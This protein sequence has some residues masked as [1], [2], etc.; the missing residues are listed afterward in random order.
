[1]R[2]KTILFKIKTLVAYTAFSTFA[3]CNLPTDTVIEERDIAVCSNEKIAEFEFV[4][5]KLEGLKVINPT[6]NDISFAIADETFWEGNGKWK[7]VNGKK[8]SVCGK[9][10]DYFV[11]DGAKGEYDWNL[12]IVPSADFTNMIEDPRKVVQDVSEWKRC[13]DGI[14]F[15]DCFQAEITPD[16]SIYNNIW[17][18]DRVPNIEHINGN[19]RFYYTQPP[20][21]A[22]NKNVG[23]Y[24]PW[25]LDG[26]H[27]WRPE[28]HPCEII[29]WRNRTISNRSD[30]MF[31]FCIQDDSNR[32]DDTDDFNNVPNSNWKPWAVPPMTAQ[33]RIPFEFKKEYADHLI[34]NIEELKT[35]HI[36]THTIDGF[37]DSDDGNN[38]ILK[39]KSATPQR[40]F[41]ND[42]AVEVNEQLSLSL[43]L[44]VKFVDICKKS[45]GNIIG[46]IQLSSAYGKGIN[47]EEG[48]HLLKI[49]I[50]YPRNKNIPDEVLYE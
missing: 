43:N 25:V 49:T 2:I 9:L 24:G 1:M 39:I 41:T 32:Y 10:I 20:S 4:L 8:I 15:Y 7:P 6:N 19:T 17:F 46:Y 33:L 47:G 30:T 38:H 13:K 45:N 37:G 40:I 22:L 35:R 27:G 50:N 31:V 23:V 34:V 16:E 21:L 42:I 44:G 3:S 36:V 12:N 11:Y 26:A 5:N 29:W 48:Y 18:P 28:I 14:S